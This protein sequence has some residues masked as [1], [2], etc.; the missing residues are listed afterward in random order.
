MKYYQIVV[1]THNS[2]FYL[3]FR[4]SFFKKKKKKKE[5]KKEKEEKKEVP[6]ETVDLTSK[7]FKKPQSSQNGKCSPVTFCLDFFTESTESTAWDSNRNQSP[8]SSHHLIREETKVAFSSN[9]PRKQFFVHLC[10]RKLQETNGPCN[11]SV[12]GRNYI[13]FLNLILR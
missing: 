13:H 7:S 1:T 8:Y 2:V 11:F 12:L 4:N 9:S 6:A 3:I 5:R 10:Y